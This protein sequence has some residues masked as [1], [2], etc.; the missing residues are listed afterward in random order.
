MGTYFAEISI[1]YFH[2]SMDDLE[3][4]KLVVEFVNPADEEQRGVAAINDLCFTRLEGVGIRAI[5]DE[6]HI[7]TY[8]S[9]CSVSSARKE[10]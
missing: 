8:L 3:G 4:R 2:I 6:L 1:E 10:I 5:G 9:P 7:T